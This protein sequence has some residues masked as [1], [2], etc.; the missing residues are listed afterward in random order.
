MTH[1]QC[2]VVDGSIYCRLC[3]LINAE[4]KIAAFKVALLFI[5]SKIHFISVGKTACCKRNPTLNL[6]QKT[7]YSD[8]INKLHLTKL[9]LKIFFFVVVNALHW[10]IH[11]V[12]IIYTNVYLC[13]MVSPAAQLTGES[14]LKPMSKLPWYQLLRLPVPGKEATRIKW[15]RDLSLLILFSR[16]MMWK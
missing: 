5:I 14:R 15:C 11:N 9:P 4:E 3:W 2:K 6:H 16:L 12:T 1:H 7:F 8:S 10:I 13:A